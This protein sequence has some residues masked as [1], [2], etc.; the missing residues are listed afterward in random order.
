MYY[1]ILVYIDFYLTVSTAIVFSLISLIEVLYVVSVISVVSVTEVLSLFSYFTHK[2]NFIII[3]IL[4]VKVS[5]SISCK[6]PFESFTYPV[7]N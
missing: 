6:F 3:F 1:A 7:F 5:P 4:F 2:F